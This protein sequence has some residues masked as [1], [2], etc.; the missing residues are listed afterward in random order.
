[1]NEKSLIAAVRDDDADSVRSMLPTGE[2]PDVVDH[3]GLPLLHV[4]VGAFAGRVV[5]ELSWPLQQLNR[6]APDGR[7]PL[8]RAIDLGADDIVETLISSG[9]EL[10]HK[11]P[12]GRDALALARRWQQTGPEAELR[13]RTGA[14]GPVS[15]RTVRIEDDAATCEE[16]S[17]GGLTVR[18]GHAAIL[19][20]LEPRYGITPPFEVL[21]SRALAEP[22]P[23]HPVWTAALSTLHA[24]RDP[25]LW[26]SA[27]A[28]RDRANP[29]E[30][31]FGAEVLRWTALFDESDDAP[32]DEPIVDLF[33]PW[34]EREP[35]L[36]VMRTL[37]AGLADAVSPRTTERLIALADHR[38]RQVRQWAVSGL[39]WAVRERRPAAT[40]T[41]V[42][43]TRD[44]DPG[45][46]RQACRLL[47]SAPA[48]HPDAADTLAACL[49]DPD[50]D[51][52]I[53]AAI[54][55]ALHDD[56]RGDELLNGLTDVSEDS[57]WYWELDA[58]WRRRLPEDTG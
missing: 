7:T 38:D 15:R 57:P 11:D 58:V 30:R 52:R 50:E 20:R 36:R 3:H 35:D 51:V 22:D 21:M 31:L 42:R 4:A 48:D 17:L 6:R 25:A 46:R 12:E 54:Q 29:L 13:H 5:Q 47:G 39:H 1:M 40:A 53:T 44:D 14:S 49:D 26:E 37:A 32:C 10:W 19:T 56:P 43:L 2:L 33:L 27:A 23:D 24:R 55:L 8:L 9:A 28:L 41:A 16:L 45:I 18:T 34:S